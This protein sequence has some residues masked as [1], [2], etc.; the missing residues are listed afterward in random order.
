M[1]EV[2]RIK[3]TTRDST[4]YVVKRGY[5][6]Q[7]LFEDGIP[8]SLAYVGVRAEDCARVLF[9]LEDAETPEQML[10][11]LRTYGWPNASYELLTPEPLS[12][13][14][15]VEEDEYT[16]IDEKDAEVIINVHKLSVHINR[17]ENGVLRAKI[18]HD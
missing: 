17:T 6:V 15:R 4:R 12:V 1:S 9:A 16:L 14:K 5:S 18:S 13:L 3:C 11:I 8:A 7:C 10:Q 2:I